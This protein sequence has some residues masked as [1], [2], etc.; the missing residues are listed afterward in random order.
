MGHKFLETGDTSHLK[1]SIYWFLEGLKNPFISGE[2]ESAMH[3]NLGYYYS[4][5]GTEEMDS[6]SLYHLDQMI[7]IANRNMAASYLITDDFE[8]KGEY[9]KRKKNYDSALVLFSRGLEIIDK[10][11]SNFRIGDYPRPWSA[12]S[13][14]DLLKRNK[15][16]AYFNLYSTYSQLGNF[17]K[18]LENYIQ[19]KKAEDEL[20]NKQNQDLISI[21][22]AESENEKTENQIASLKRDKEINALKA[23]QSRN[24]S[25][26][27][28]SVFI[29]LVLVGLLFLR[30]NKL[31][32][33]H[34]RTILEQKLLRLQM[35]PYFIF[36]ALSSIHSLMN[37]KD[38]TRASDYLGNF[39]RLLRTSLESSREDYIL[40]DDEI[41][42]LG[43]YLEL[44]RLR[45][46]E[47]FDYKIDID[48]KIDLE[49]A[50]IPPMLIQPFIENA[51]E[52]GIKHKEGLGN[53]IIRF[54][55]NDKKIT[56]EIEDDGIG[57]K[58]A[59]EVE[60]AQQ[61]KQKSLATEIIRDRIKI[62]NK[63]MKQKINLD[64][65]D[66]RSGANEATGTLVRLDLPY[67]LD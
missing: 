34:K 47:K 65:T 66:L 22:E 49:S 50:I 62:L 25:F 17:G 37:P 32:N 6:L 8:Y 35:N 18:A 52:H 59:W 46:D 57:R 63:K 36:N 40:L 5:F 58:K 56:C 43:N 51:I 67:L 13:N 39:S 2:L 48:P 64:I 16:D 38:V 44:Q 9:M 29:V 21:L 45:Y 24:L 28:G 3:S 31:K 41:S 15:R 19:Y 23:T 26:G 10:Q 14:R 4:L 1:K 53:I 11:L 30:Q 20:L 42:S 33:E 54:I 27:I 61:G 60:Y 7:P 55:V 12:W